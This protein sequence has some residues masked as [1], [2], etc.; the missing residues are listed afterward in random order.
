MRRCFPARFHPAAI[1]AIGILAWPAL[2]VGQAPNSSPAPATPVLVELFT[3]EGCSD[4]PPADDL[5]SRLDQEQPIPGVHVVVLSEHVTYWNHDGW[6]DPF[7]MI[8]M[9][10][11]QND[12]AARFHLQSAYTPQAIVDGAE[13]LVGNSSRKVV[14]A[15]VHQAA[16]PTKPLEITMAALEKGSVRF[17]VQA[18]DVQSDHLYAALAQDVTRSEVNRGENAGRT[19]H[20]VAVV[21]QMKE[22]RSKFADGHEISIS[23]GNLDRRQGGGAVRLVVFLVDPHSGRV[24]GAAEHPLSAEQTQTSAR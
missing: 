10:G 9:D 19:L 2:S 11:R 18:P 15:I 5:L 24:D 3:S 17:T 7:S 21:R 14:D 23:T 12:Y 22:F 8:E 16:Q 20:H 1:A 13:Q 4:C 6:T